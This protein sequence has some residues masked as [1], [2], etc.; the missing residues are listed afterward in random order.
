MARANFLQCYALPINKQTTVPV[1]K[2]LPELKGKTISAT[3]STLDTL[4]DFDRFSSFNKVKRAAAY[5]LR[6]IHNIRNSRARR[7]GSLSVSELREAQVLATRCAQMQSFP[8]LYNCLRNNTPITKCSEAN[9]VLGLNVFLDDKKLIRVGGRLCES[10]SFSYN[11]RHP[12]LLCT[13]HNF[14][15]ILFRYQHQILLHAGP[16]LLL[17]T[18]RENWWPLSG[19]NLARKTVHECVTCARIKGQTLAPLMGNIPKQ[20]L[21]AGF[22]FAR[23][24]VDYAGP[25]YILSRRGRGSRLVKAYICLFI[26]FTTKAIHLELVS[27]LTTD[28]YILALKRF[29][30]RR[31]KPMEIFSDNGKNFV[32]AVKEFPLLLPSNLD[33]IIDFTASDGIKFSFI[34]PYAPH[35]GG[36]WEGGVKSCKHFLRRTVGNARL[37]FEEFYTVLAQIEA[38]LNSRPLNP[39]SSDPTDNLP[40]TPAH[41]LIGRPLT[42]PACDDVTEIQMNRLKRYHRVEQL[43]QQFWKRWSLEYVA[44]LQRRTKWKTDA[45]DIK[46]DSLVLIKEDNLPP[47]KWR[48]GRIIRV[49]PGKDGISRVAEIRTQAGTIQRAFSKIC[50]LPLTSNDN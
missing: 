30:S 9:K 10:S 25:V 23:T 15:R 3:C 48:L 28:D 31:G 13:K 8:T 17:C 46:L 47:L 42:A 2:N 6:F 22:P 41:F 1:C 21:E 39:M 35:F 34:P 24:G 44:E 40:L 19:R 20:R 27:G 36:L 43:R 33:K 26:C 38:I 5:V 12:V 4:F 37:T 7:T 50:P 29:I 11:K 45:D 14:T 32:G 18:I 49:F 16:Q